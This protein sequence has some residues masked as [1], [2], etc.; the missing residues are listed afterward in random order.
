MIEVDNTVELAETL[1]MKAYELGLEYA[2]K[3]ALAIVTLIIGLW[4]I[5]GIGKLVNISMKQS[6][7]DPTLYLLWKV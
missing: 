4:I 1:S 5:R 2:P 3:L 7:V 6:K